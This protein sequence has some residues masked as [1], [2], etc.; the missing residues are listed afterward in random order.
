MNLLEEKIRR[1][2][3][4]IFNE[5]KL[6]KQHLDRLI[7]IINNTIIPPYEIIIQPSSV[8]NLRCM[9]CIGKNIDE[10]TNK[11]M[12][13]R[14]SN[15][16]S[17]L[18][19]IKGIIDYKKDIRYEDNEIRNYKVEKIQFSGLTGEP[20]VCKEPI[21]AAM[22]ELVKNDR[23]VGM[24]TN[25]ILMDESTWETLIDTNYVLVSVDAG[26]GATYNS[27]KYPDSNDDIIG[28]VHSNINGLIKLRN[29]R[30]SNLD[31]NA[32]FVINPDNYKELYMAAKNLK[33]IGIHY[34]RIKTD[35]SSTYNLS[36]DQIK[37]SEEI[38]QETKL[39]LEDDY[40][41]IIEIHKI[42]DNDAKKRNFSKCYMNSIMSAISADGE[43]YP[44]NYQT[45]IGR[46]PYGNV[47]DKPFGDVFEM[48][49]ERD[50]RYKIP[51]NCPKVCDPFKNRS[52]RLFE[53]V[54]G[55]YHEYGL[56]ALKAYIREL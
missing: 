49:I 6:I 2:I 32:G 28:K 3:P 34:L 18:K 46:Q 10:Y 23:Q 41:K 13:Q 51:E 37:E 52:N 38:L 44:C 55:I 8:C 48:K 22:R 14:L 5:K 50:L 1:D 27:M 35:I 25:G 43:M 36:S 54:E 4:E 17:M 31:V 21:L 26:Q 19:M 30:Q 24:F 29:R 20:L 42:Y 45:K 12:D 33:D 40:F 56:E 11:L 7:C 39:K 47:I 16:D 15:V 9:W 53:I